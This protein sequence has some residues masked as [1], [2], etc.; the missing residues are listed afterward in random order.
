MYRTISLVVLSGMLAGCQS[1][2]T[3]EL[4][5]DADAC[6]SYG[7]KDGTSEMAN[8]RMQQDTQRGA[9]PISRAPGRR[10]AGI[11]SR[12]ASGY[13][14][15]SSSADELYQYGDRHRHGEHIL[16]LGLVEIFKLLT[17]TTNG[18]PPLFQSTTD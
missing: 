12:S 11:S 15:S 5:A 16:Q 8:C 13:P 17:P 18:S 14:D 9:R 2:R 3:D 10:A 6:R 7:F 4:R 1:T